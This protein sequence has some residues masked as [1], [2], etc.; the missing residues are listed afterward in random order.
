M[1]LQSSDLAFV[2]D[3]VESLDRTRS[4]DEAIEVLHETIV[5]LGF[6]QLAYGWTRSA[7]HANGRWAAVPVKTR[8]FPT[9]WDRDWARHSEHDTYFHTAF[10]N[11]EADWDEV[12]SR[13]ESFTQA[14]RD[15]IN[16]SSDLGLHRGL[17]LGIGHRGQFTYISAV[18]EPISGDGWHA[19]AQATKPVFKLIANYFHNVIGRRFE[20][21]IQPPQPLSSRELECLNWSAQG[22]TAGEIAIIL[23]I[24]METVKIYLKRINQKLDAVNRAHA[25]ALAM[26]LGMIDVART[27]A[28]CAKPG[29]TNVSQTI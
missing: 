18:G 14:E 24:S 6:P 23:S 12:R 1:F 15:C 19:T 17:T 9:H 4:F 22:K 5:G 16:Y 20:R 7:Q 13:S 3:F 27:Q 10:L 2:V 8:G 11:G 29:S 21:S 28:D 26:G 25:V